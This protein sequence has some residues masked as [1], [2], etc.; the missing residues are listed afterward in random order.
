[1]TS[2]LL[3]PPWFGL[4]CSAD[5]DPKSYRDFLAT[6]AQEFA[7]AISPDGHWIAYCSNDTGT[8]Q[9]YVQRF[10]EGGGRVA[11]SINGGWY[12][13]WSADGSALSYLSTDTNRAMVRLPVTGLQGP[14]KS[15]MFGPPKELFPWKYFDIANGGRHFDMTADGKRFLMITRGPQGEKPNRLVLVQN[16]AQELKRLVPTK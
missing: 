1:M 13:Y 2:S 3:G 7:A 16:W 6:P 14:D 5:D 10:P 11:V 4:T 12:P 8:Y 9:V 15:P